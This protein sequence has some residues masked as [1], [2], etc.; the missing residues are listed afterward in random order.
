MKCYSRKNPEKIET[1]ITWINRN[2][3]RLTLR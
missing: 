2:P 3:L 1:T